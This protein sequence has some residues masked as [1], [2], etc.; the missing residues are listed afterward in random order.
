MD[1]MTPPKIS[2]CWPVGFRYCRNPLD[3]EGSRPCKR[4]VSAADKVLKEREARS[5]SGSHDVT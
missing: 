2:P 5:A 3:P 1:S 4:L